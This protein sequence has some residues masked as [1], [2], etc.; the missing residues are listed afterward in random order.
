M[1]VE[2]SA[3]GFQWHDSLMPIGANYTALEKAIFECACAGCESIW[4]TVNDSWAPLIKERIGDYIFDPVWYYRKYDVNPRDGRKLIPI[5]VVPHM[6]KYRG[7]RDSLGWGIL[8][9]AIFAKSTFGHLSDYATPNMFYAAFIFGAYNPRELVSERSVISSTNKF[10]LTHKGKSIKDGA[11]LG[12]TFSWEEVKKINAYISSEGTGEWKAIGKF[13]KG[14][15]SAWSER[16]PVEER[17]SARNFT[18]DEVFTTLEFENAHSLE[19]SWF[20]DI[21]SWEGYK[22]FMGSENFLKRPAVLTGAKLPPIGV[23]DD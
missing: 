10:F 23:D 17:Y 13:V 16:L 18:L 19:V 8:N 20:Y 12:F 14:D 22:K 2:S 11:R 6:T 21:S 1:E 9:S 5:F 7:R 4:I 3:F 15:R